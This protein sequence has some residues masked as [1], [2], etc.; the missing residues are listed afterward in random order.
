MPSHR[1]LLLLRVE[2]KGGGVGRSGRRLNQISDVGSM[3]LRR[4]GT[5]ESVMVVLCTQ[6]EWEVG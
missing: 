3:A 5:S 4:R 2:G 6:S 1:K